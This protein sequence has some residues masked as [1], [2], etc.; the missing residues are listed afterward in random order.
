[1]VRDSKRVNLFNWYAKAIP[2]PEPKLM[3][4]RWSSNFLTPFGTNERKYSMSFVSN[5][6][7]PKLTLTVYRL[8]ESGMVKN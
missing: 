8:G 6:R 3:E 2:N 5:G 7:L 1:M 4:S